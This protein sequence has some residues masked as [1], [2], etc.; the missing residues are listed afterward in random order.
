MKDPTD[1]VIQA[2]KLIAKASEH[3]NT[4]DKYQVAKQLSNTMETVDLLGEEATKEALE[5]VW[6]RPKVYDL[7]VSGYEVEGDNYLLQVVDSTDW[8]EV[9]YGY[10]IP[11]HC[12][13]YCTLRGIDV[14]HNYGADY[15]F[16]VSEWREPQ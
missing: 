14:H 15:Y 3:Y 10:Q 9:E 12:R 13:F 1:S 2:V 6:K 11:P 16:F 5:S 7:I 8:S 4:H